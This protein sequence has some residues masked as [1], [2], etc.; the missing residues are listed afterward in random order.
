[1]KPHQPAGL[2]ITDDHR[3]N[4]ETLQICYDAAELAADRWAGERK[5]YSLGPTRRGKTGWVRQVLPAPVGEAQV[6]LSGAPTRVAL[7]PRFE[8]THVI[9]DLST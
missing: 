4:M 2:H 6:C 3:L 5:V 1:M 7:T 8:C 9:P